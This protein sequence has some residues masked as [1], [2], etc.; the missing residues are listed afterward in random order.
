MNWKYLCVIGLLAI[1]VSPVSADI[2]IPNPTD[3]AASAFADGIDIAMVRTGDS[4][5]S[6]AGCH[7]QL[8]TDLPNGTW[9]EGTTYTYTNSSIVNMIIGFASWSIMPFEY[10]SVQR[11]LGITF[12]LSIGILIAYSMLGA[13]Y[14]NLNRFSPKG[15]TF[16]HIMDGGSTD[17]AL[18]NYAQNMVFGC[19]AMSVMPALIYLC[20]VFAK[21]MKEMSMLSIAEMIAP[22]E[23]IPFL[24]LT[25]A[26]MWLILS[27][28][29]GVS[30]LVILT[31]GAGAFILGALYTSD[32]TRHIT[33]R[34]MEYF[35]GCVLMQAIV[36]GGVVLCIAAMTEMATTYP[37]AWA[38]SG[39][40]IPMYFGVIF[41]A[42]YIAYRL[43]MGKTKLIQTTSRLVAKV[44]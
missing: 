1:C 2:T 18:Q 26:I 27:L 19:V 28:F 34:W 29:F 9:D 5:L 7:D 39:V 33:T 16:Y 4:L 37:L 25:M 40:D 30:N 21:I 13:A 6:I 36:V 24:Y 17:N 3:M 15:K 12:I 20:L 10:Q 41:G 31:T 23:A 43:T 11:L 22:G 42:T 44:V 32:R 35:F 14:C 8:P 38:V